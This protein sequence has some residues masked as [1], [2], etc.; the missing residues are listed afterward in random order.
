MEINDN[1]KYGWT[2]NRERSVATEKYQFDLTST[3]KRTGVS[4]KSP[5]TGDLETVPRA[6]RISSFGPQ[7]LL[8]F[9]VRDAAL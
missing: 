3:V 6:G 2:S 8:Q 9:L 1:T 4:S 7:P 5:T